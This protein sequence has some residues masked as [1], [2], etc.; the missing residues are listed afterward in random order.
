MNTR[1]NDSIKNDT[2]STNANSSSSNKDTT[3]SFYDGWTDS[4][5][6][7]GKYKLPLQ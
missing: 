7:N 3:L 5:Q 2:S 4:N 6:K 1:S